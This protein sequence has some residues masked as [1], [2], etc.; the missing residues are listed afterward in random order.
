[1]S[2]RK[3]TLY[4]ILGVKSDV[5]PAEIKR[6]YR[7]LA[8][9][10]HP[11]AR[12]G[13]RESEEKKAAHEEMMRLN[14]AYATLMDAGKRAEYDLKIGVKQM[15]YVKPVFSSL[16]ED[17]EREKFLRTIFHPT[18]SS[19]VKVLNLYK[20]ELHDLSADPYDDELIEHFIAYV[21]KIEETL[22]SG[23]E[24]LGANV[25]P[26]TLQPSVHMMKYSIAQAADGLEELRYFC[27]NYD[28]KHLTMAENLF[29]I[30]HDLSKEALSLS[31]GR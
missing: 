1:M 12:D 23:A 28:Y 11:D 9:E 7:Q 6:A 27:R 4:Q 17:R 15:I 3:R 29:R 31:K 8:K 22:R 30:S 21:D 19:I 26:P 16:D 24:A 13:H 5:S 25:P 18:R 10:S 20:K 2:A 14:E